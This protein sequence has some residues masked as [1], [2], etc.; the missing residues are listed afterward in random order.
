VEKTY[1]DLP[2]HEIFDGK[3]LKFRALKYHRG[4]FGAPSVASAELG[5]AAFNMLCQKMCEVFDEFMQLPV[6]HDNRRGI[7]H[8]AKAKEKKRVSKARLP[9]NVAVGL[10]VGWLLFR[11]LDRENS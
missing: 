7:A 8:K 6:R 1:Q 5:S 10:A 2:K 11:A 4:Y 9:L 3:Q